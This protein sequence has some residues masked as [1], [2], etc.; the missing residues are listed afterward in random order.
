[1]KVLFM[2]NIPSPY[3]V[4]FFNE[5]GKMCDLTVT[6]EGKVATDRNEKWKSER[7]ENY[8]QI[9]LKGIRTG[10]DNFF[11]P[12]ITKVIKEGFDHIILGVYSTPTSMYAMEYMKKRNIKYWIEADGGFIKENENVFKRKLKRYFISSACGWFS[13]G[14]MTTDFLCYYGAERSK[15]YIYPFT[16]LRESDILTKPPTIEEKLKIRAELGIGGVSSRS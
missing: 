3:R 9:T 11:C 16:S 1:M 5:F 10:S 12:G 4:D 2:S 6:F 14:K 13:S 7:A 8:R 15:C